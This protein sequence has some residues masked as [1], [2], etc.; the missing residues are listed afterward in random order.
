MSLISAT[1][2]P[3]VGPQRESINPF[4]DDFFPLTCRPSALLDLGLMGISSYNGGNGQGHGPSPLGASGFTPVD[5]SHQQPYHFG[6]QYTQNSL[7]IPTATDYHTPSSGGSV[8]TSPVDMVMSA[9]M[10]APSLSATNSLNSH[11]PHTPNGNSPPHPGNTQHI[12]PAQNQYRS[13]SASATDYRTGS[14]D[15]W[16]FTTDV[17]DTSFSLPTMTVSAP[18]S[19]YPGSGGEGHQQ[20]GLMAPANIPARPSS[21]SGAGS[22]RSSSA[23]VVNGPGI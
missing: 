20:Q 15:F 4:E 18:S 8:I 1:L 3:T 7:T 9:S 6:N 10:S 17:A 21:Q 13:L 16:G 11:S 19:A 14:E 5:P 23:G 22:R 12:H 2:I